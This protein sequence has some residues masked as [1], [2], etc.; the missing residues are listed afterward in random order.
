MLP[1]PKVLKDNPIN[2]FTG[3]LIETLFFTNIWIFFY[4]LL[5]LILR[6]KFPTAVTEGFLIPLNF[7]EPFEIPL[8]LAL[9]LLLVIVIF[10]LHKY[11]AVL[12]KRR[13][14]NS[15]GKMINPIRLI[16]LL[17]LSALYIKHISEPLIGGDFSYIPQN[18]QAFYLIFI[19]LYL[20]GIA[21]FILE[22]GI[23]QKLL[24]DKQKQFLI[25]F[26]GLVLLLIAFITFQARFPI[27]GNSYSF[28]Y[29]PI[30][31]VVQ[32]KTI[33][34]E[35]PSQYAFLFILI[36]SV[37]SRLALFGLS[38]LPVVVWI[39][40]IIQYFLGF[41]LIHKISR[42]AVLAVIGLF[43]IIT[44]NYLYLY[45]ILEQAPQYPI[46]WI[47]LIAGIY[48]LDKFKQIDS[49]KFVICISLLSLL[50]VES[51]IYL[52]LT[53]LLSIFLLTIEQ[54][55]SL[56]RAVKAVFVFFSSLFLIFLS[57]NLLHLISGRQPI[58]FIL[59][60]GRIILFSK[61]GFL[62]LPIASTTYF[63]L[64]ILIF[65]S[66]SI[67]FFK[68]WING[69][70]YQPVLFATNA[71]FVAGIYYVGD[72]RPT[73]L[74]SLT[75]LIILGFFL[76]LG[77][78][79]EKLK[80]GRIKTIILLG[81]ALFCIVLPTYIRKEFIADTLIGKFKSLS[82]PNIFQPE[83]GDIVEK[84]YVK[85]I[86][87]I[88]RNLTGPK[89]V[90]IHN[91]ETYL[92][93]LTRKK[94]LL[95]INPQMGILTENEIDFALRDAVKNCPKRIAVDCDLVGKCSYSH[96]RTMINSA[97]YSTVDVEKILF[98]R[99]QSKCNLKYI[100]TVCTGDLCIT[101]AN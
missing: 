35:T 78:F 42:S 70:T 31:E 44:V 25:I 54:T 8:Y 94:N 101:Q 5:L 7:P 14:I 11:K 19:V 17:C 84:K 32:G 41:L 13:S 20:S 59:L 69:Q 53:F 90:I 72:S 76:M 60:F 92:F 26:Y 89:I 71:M 46:R 37:L 36:M 93:Y 27:K 6:N 99:F 80:S 79:F 82:R 56:K 62:F 28:F 23:M 38:T 64:V 86:D 22:T 65:F 50:S 9:S 63:W 83:I 75:L 39:L 30:R 87:L 45:D 16:I 1:F 3:F 96:R 29:G 68:K 98:E 100:P 73:Y 95:R 77:Y 43:S 85:E 57:V 12:L 40:Y 18:S 97:T 15:E 21:V 2:E 10:L 58:D 61:S 66:S 91:D 81:V 52:I 34:T 4:K 33:F 67:L 24:K 49:K 51:G 55:L 88:N 47:G 48:F 74:F